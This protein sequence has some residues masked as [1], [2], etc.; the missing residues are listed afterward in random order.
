MKGMKNM[1]E[2]TRWPCFRRFPSF[3][4]HVLHDLHGVRRFRNQFYPKEFDHPLKSNSRTKELPFFP[5]SL[6]TH[7]S[8]RNS[9]VN[10]VAWHPFAVPLVALPPLIHYEGYPAVRK[11]TFCLLVALV[12][13]CC[14]SPSIAFGVDYG[15][16]MPLGD[17]ITAG[18]FVDGGYREP[19]FEQ[20]GAAGDTFQFVGTGSNWPTTALTEA[21]QE[22]HEGHSGYIIDGSATGA[23]RTGLYENAASWMGTTGTNRPDVILL[24]IGT[25]DMNVGG[26]YEVDGAP[27]RLDALISRIADKTTG[28]E[29][30]AKL[31]VASVVASKDATTE[32]N[33][34]A[35][36]T[37]VPELV[38]QHRA[39]G[40][41]VFY[42]DMYNALDATNDLADSLHPNQAGYDKMGEAWSKAMSASSG[43]AITTTGLNV[44][45]TMAKDFATANH[46]ADQIR[47][48]DLIDASSSTLASWSRADD[49][50]PFFG[51]DRLNDGEGHTDSAGESQGTYWPEDFGDSR[52]QLP[53]TYTYNLDTTEN[54]LGY[55]LHE[56]CSYAGWNENGAA[57]GN[58][59]YEL[60]VSTVG[61]DSFT[62]LGIFEYSPFEDDD[63]NA[64][65]ATKMALTSN[66]GTIA[67][68]VDAVQFVL[69]NHGKSNVNAGIDGTVYFEIDVLGV[70]TV[71][72]PTSVALL[73]IGG[74]CLLGLYRRRRHV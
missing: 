2:G 16:V 1:C 5:V 56:I 3:C 25:N 38:A 22:K 52:Q 45:S 4:L 40:E 27:A 68:G 39:A 9:R 49:K 58:Q 42:V 36:N 67:R 18:Y 34:R 54:T 10:G 6:L 72:E 59:K 47:S 51:Q 33:V 15:D 44:S 11:S 41:N 30:N 21:G 57:L 65:S 50:A 71:P 35:F 17:S 55:D 20:L 64:A 24:M 53:V 63:P 19:L 23:P 7:S 12:W 14:A 70:A 32:A 73:G 69:M 28:L 13:T 48:D 62:S 31:M 60:L 26:G 74:L 37:K 43:P 46:F 66:T 8:S 29:P 61:D